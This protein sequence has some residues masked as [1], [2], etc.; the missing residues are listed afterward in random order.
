MG[1][2]S[3][4]GFD[5]I[6]ITQSLFWGK[7]M[8]LEWFRSNAPTDPEQLDKY[9]RV[10]SNLSLTWDVLIYS[11]LAI[12]V[13]LAWCI[14]S[15]WYNKGKTDWPTARIVRKIPLIGAYLR[16]LGFADSMMASA[17]MLRGLVPIDDA[18][19]QASEATT[20]PEVSEYWKQANT[21]LARGVNLGAALDRR[22]LSR[23]ERLELASLSDLSQVATVMESIA[24][25]RSAAAKT[26]HSLIVWIAFGLTGLYLAIAFGSAIYALTVMNMSMDSMM[27]G[28]L[29]GA[30]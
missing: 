15:Y 1:T 12:G 25:M 5:V 28:L 14:F 4:L 27:G 7:D 17:R 18:L 10:V 20:S 2:M 30:M 3:W 22:P 13:F 8:V 23:A 24:D 26:K 29:Q 6:T 16:D 9:T 11:C 21:D 19:R